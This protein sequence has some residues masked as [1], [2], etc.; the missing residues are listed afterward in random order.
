MQKKYYCSEIVD[1]ICEILS[2]IASK[3]MSCLYYN[4]PEII[5][6]IDQIRRPDLLF[7]LAVKT[8][9]AAPFQVLINLVDIASKE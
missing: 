8:K 4:S 6:F 1:N 5:P 2:E 9:R 3:N 7:N